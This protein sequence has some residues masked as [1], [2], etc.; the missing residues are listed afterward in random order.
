MVENKNPRRVCIYFNN[1]N[2]NTLI[3]LNQLQVLRQCSR[4]SA[5]AYLLNYYEIDHLNSCG[6]K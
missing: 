1:E 3:R 6:S 5:I 4:A 2:K